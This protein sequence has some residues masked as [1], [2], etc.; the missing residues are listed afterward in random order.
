MPFDQKDW[1]RRLSQA[2]TQEEFSALIMELP[3]EPTPEDG[4][5][6]STTGVPRPSTP[7]FLNTRSGKIQVG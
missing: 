1:E 4:P 5:A 6:S 3:E 2:K 7:L